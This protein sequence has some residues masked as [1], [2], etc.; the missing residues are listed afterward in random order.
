MRKRESDRLEGV[1]R[2]NERILALCSV[3]PTEELVVV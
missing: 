1:D 3:K 2:K